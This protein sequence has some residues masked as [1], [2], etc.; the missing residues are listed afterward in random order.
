MEFDGSRIVFKSYLKCKLINYRSGDQIEKNEMAGARSTYGER[1]GVYC[2]RFWWGKPEGKRP[3]G[4]RIL[5]WIF[6]KGGVRACTVFI[7]LRQ[8]QVTGTCKCG[9]VP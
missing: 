4:G 9:N 2:T 8:R 6:R 1:K 7:W 5:R 3:L